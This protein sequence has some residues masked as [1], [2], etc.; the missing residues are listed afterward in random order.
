MDPIIVVPYDSAWPEQ[1]QQIA[2]NLRASLG[3]LALRIDHIG[4]TAVPG[5]AAKPVIDIQISVAS[6]EPFVPLREAMEACGFVHRTDNTELTKRY[7][8]E[9]AGQPR[10]HIHMREHGSLSEQ[11]A[12]VFRDYLRAHPTAADEYARVKYEF[13]AHYRDDREGYVDAKEPFIWTTF[14]AASDW[15]QRVGWRP[16]PSDA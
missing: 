12:L 6:F 1:F 13:A 11:L 14:R 10:T 15:S 5:L 4:S 3:D 8:R 16:A 7:F 2:R 9:R